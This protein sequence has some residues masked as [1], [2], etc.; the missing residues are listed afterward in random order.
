MSNLEK[1]YI[2]G[3]LDGEGCFSARLMHP[4]HH[5][6]GSVEIRVEVH[7]C[8]IAM[9]EALQSFYDSIDVRYRLYLGR[10]Q[11]KSTRPAHLICVDRKGDVKRVIESVL[12]Y[13][14][15]KKPEALLCLDWL[16]EY[17]HDLRGINQYTKSPRPNIKE[18]KEFVC[19]MKELK[20]VA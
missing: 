13:L 20:R 17:G 5:G 9:I 15:V 10:W 18:K 7:T 14:R 19:R 8:S 6:G 4:E 16:N 1:A 3:I 11:P 12:P 2:A